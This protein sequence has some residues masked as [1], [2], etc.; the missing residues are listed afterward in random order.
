M[1]LWDHLSETLSFIG[2][3]ITGITG[4]LITIK[5]QRTNRNTATR[6]SIIVDQSGASAG[7]DIFGGNNSTKN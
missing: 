1:F 3:V 6:G 5:I 2:G 7:R 4:S